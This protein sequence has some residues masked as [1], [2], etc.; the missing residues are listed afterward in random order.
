MCP[1]TLISFCKTLKTSLFIAVKF[2]DP[3]KNNAENEG[4][5]RRSNI[6][7]NAIIVVTWK[8]KC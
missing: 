6:Y 5:F 3:D 1:S 4:F 8:N 2:Y 7:K